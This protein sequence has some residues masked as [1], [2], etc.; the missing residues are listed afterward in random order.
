[1]SQS[2]LQDAQR[3]HRSGKA[4][5]AARLYTE[6]LRT[7]PN[8]LHALYPLGLL[9]FQAGIYGE[10]ERLM[11]RACQINP[12]MAEA[13]FVRG[14][15]LQRLNRIEEAL[16]AFAEAVTIKPMFVEALINRGAALLALNRQQE[17][18]ADFRAVLGI[19]PSNPGVWSNC[20]CI[21]QNLRRPEEALTC[22]DRALALSPDFVEALYNRGSALLA[23]KRYAEAGRTYEK[24]LAINPELP[25]VRSHVVFCRLQCCDWAH[26]AEDR[27]AVAEGIRQG[28]AIVQP[29]VN[30]RM[31][32]TP[33]DHLACARIYGRRWP[34]VQNPLWRGERYDHAK[35]RVAYISADFCDHAT[36][37]LAAGLFEH[38]DRAR[39]ETVAISLYPDDSSEMRLRT[40][41]AFDGFVD[42]EGLSDE[43]AAAV[44]R[45][46]EID[47][48]VDLMGYAANCRPGILAQRPAPLQ[49]NYLGYPGTMGVPYFDYIIADPTVIP[50][51]HRA[52]YS[53]KIAAL[54]DT[55]Q[56]NDSKRRIAEH[57]PTRED[58]GLPRHGFVFCCFNDPSKIAPEFFGVWMQLLQQVEGSVLWLLENNTDATSNLK[59]EARNRGIDPARL[60]F[61]PHLKLA[62]HLAR[63][64]LADL[65]L[66]TLPYGAHTTASD[67][68]WAGLPVL[69]CLGGT[70]PG[71]V[72]ASLLQA[73]GMPELIAPSLEGYEVFALR[74]ARDS[75]FLSGL[76]AKLARNRK[77]EA[78]FD[79]ARFTRNLEAA[80][81][82]MCERQRRGEMPA[83]FR[84]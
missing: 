67:S 55:Y 72:A 3:L 5:E 34:P 49:V 22:F 9:R 71:R 65:F 81:I 51:E 31:P 17:A 57:T 6:V 2:L 46:L 52:F 35:I 25:D 48:A 54:P 24:L 61:A 11:G 19:N 50:D 28:R 75:E 43:T 8:Q 36:S 37:W 32:S 33:E 80:F 79:T 10:A 45:R 58:V 68:L 62:D 18:L 20:G 4:E 47:I 40:R 21:L 73:V 66:D 23:L 60:V 29:L 42:A 14:C 59:S 7:E 39:F 13:H 15:C 83:D 77:T 38:H 44:M 56:C 74:C 27:A 12:R 41:K 53:E 26:L 69:T 84:V 16:S 70:F 30:T 82:T 1:M 64:R 63:H 78:L 76:K